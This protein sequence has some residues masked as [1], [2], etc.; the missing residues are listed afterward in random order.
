MRMEWWRTLPVLVAIVVAASAMARQPPVP[1]PFALI[2]GG[3]GPP[4]VA[5]LH[6]YCASEKDWATLAKAIKLSPDTRFIFPR[7]PE[8]ARRS[9]GAPGGRAW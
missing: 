3:K 5:P 2:K 9:D 8:S 1:R 7:A 4:T 6:G